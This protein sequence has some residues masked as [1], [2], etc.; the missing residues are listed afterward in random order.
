MSEA[1]AARATPTSSD[2]HAFVR[3]LSAS[4]EHVQGHDHAEYDSGLSCSCS[5]LAWLATLVTGA[6]N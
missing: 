2:A 5:A 3:M 1:D 4:H 6:S